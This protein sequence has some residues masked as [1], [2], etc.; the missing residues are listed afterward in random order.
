MIKN[1]R[2]A[3]KFGDRQVTIPN[4]SPDILLINAPLTITEVPFMA[5]AVL[6]AIANKAGYSCSTVDLNRLTLKWMQYQRQHRVN[7]RA[8]DLVNVFIS[9]GATVDSTLLNNCQ[10][11]IDQW[12]SL[13]VSL[14]QQFNP[15]ILGI[16]VFTDNS[17]LATKLIAEQIK[18][19][20]PDIKILLG[21]QGIAK[22]TRYGVSDSVSFGEKLLRD[23]LVDHYI[24]GDAE[25]SFYE[26][27]KNNLTFSGINSD[28]WQQ[29][30]NA[31][32]S[33]V[34]YP[35]YSDY[36]WKLYSN[37]V[38]GITGSRGCVRE[39]KFCD[40]IVSHSKFAWRGAENI[41]EEMLHQKNFHNIS[42][43]HFSDSLINGNMKEFK[44]LMELMSSY[45]NQ[46]PTDKLNWASFFIFRPKI[47]F[48]E[49]LWKLV[50]E[51]GCNI[52]SVGVETFSDRVREHMGKGFNNDDLEFN[53][54]MAA[55]YNI[56]LLMMMVFGY[57]TETEED[58]EENLTWLT[59]NQHHKREG[60]IF[61]IS[62]AM[63]LLPGS[64]I[65]RHKDSL[66]VIL[67]NSQN[68]ET[69][70]N[71]ETGSTH[72]VRTQR[73]NRFIKHARSLN[74]AVIDDY[75]PHALLEWSL[76]A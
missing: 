53:F 16:S 46:H 59:E 35:D 4:Y 19:H 3:F 56:K 61:W 65:D 5:G 18:K 76:V 63:V 75:D 57:V 43:F 42:S 12:L 8:A 73:R 26:F 69:W 22:G 34:P 17:R 50:A 2:P 64:W 7:S 30:N 33:V 51:S 67:L 23:G 32:L 27:L 40:F 37:R 6:K 29:L 11:E 20:C 54:N 62:T 13:C 21:G 72:A 31:S 74:F 66:N 70:I 44:K 60:F 25:N 38:I 1:E 52:L 71:T 58:F 15:K 10:K 48:K 24:Q 41:F 55:K 49:E 36:D 47:Q 68:R 39:C 28:D 14:V 9:W 45:N